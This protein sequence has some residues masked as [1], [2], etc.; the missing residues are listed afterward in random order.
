MSARRLSRLKFGFWG[1]TDLVHL[2]IEWHQSR[3]SDIRA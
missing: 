3:L 2:Q 1:V